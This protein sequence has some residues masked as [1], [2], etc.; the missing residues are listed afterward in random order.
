MSLQESC[1]L[2][3]I[4]NLEKIDRKLLKKKYHRL[5]LKYHPDKNKNHPNKFTK[6]KE[7]YEILNNYIDNNTQP[8]NSQKTDNIYETLISLISVENIKYAV[9]LLDIY[10]IYINNSPETITLNVTLKQVFDKCLYINNNHYIPL[11]HKFIHQ[12]SVKEQKHIIY[13]I[14]ITDIPSNIQVLKNN[15]IVV[16]ISKE[17][18]KNNAFN[19]I[20]ICKQVEF[21]L[22]I[23]ASEYNQSHILLKNKGIPKT[24]IYD[25]FDNS[26]LSNIHLYLD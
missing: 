15:D 18:I 7:S 22:Y 26:Q 23:S 17:N 2:F 6:I 24:N 3:Q 8:V 19:L 16:H 9:N 13:A 20:H 5:C 21:N 1:N 12:F 25:I 14:N 4:H 10:K 11:W